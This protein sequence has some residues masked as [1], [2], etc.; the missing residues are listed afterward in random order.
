MSKPI[1]ITTDPGSSKEYKTGTWRTKRPVFKHDACNDCR[2][3][4]MVCPD[5]CIFGQNNVYDADLD[6][7]KG[8]GICAEECPV[9]DID[10][11]LEVK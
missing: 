8:C 4:V 10:M 5:A 7:C 11:V 2:I 6:F 9:D 1:Q 3:C